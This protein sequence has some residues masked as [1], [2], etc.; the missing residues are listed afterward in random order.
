MKDLM[1]LSYGIAGEEKD[2]GRQAEM[3]ADG[4]IKGLA[5]MGGA[6]IAPHLSC[7]FNVIRREYEVKLVFPMGFFETDSCK[8]KEA[9]EARLAD[10]EK[11]IQDQP[12]KMIGDLAFCAEKATALISHTPEE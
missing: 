6:A 9:V 8:R 11:R 10:L 4:L 3:F 12:Q 1:E 2:P 5:G 7:S